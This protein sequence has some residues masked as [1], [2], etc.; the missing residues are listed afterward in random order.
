VVVGFGG[1]D[2]V[3]GDAEVMVRWCFVFGAGVWLTPRVFGC[4]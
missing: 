4:L 2:V 1:G 3:F